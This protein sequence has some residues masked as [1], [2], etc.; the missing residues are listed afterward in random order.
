MSTMKI[1][2]P[3]ECFKRKNDV[4][5]FDADVVVEINAKLDAQG[6]Y[7]GI[8]ISELD[9][10]VWIPAELIKIGSMVRCG[11]CGDFADVE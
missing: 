5:G 1:V 7:L 9:K 8:Y 10:T 6:N 2:C 4:P 11:C 3:N